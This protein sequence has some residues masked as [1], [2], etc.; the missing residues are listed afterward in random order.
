MAAEHQSELS[1]P[2]PIGKKP[3]EVESPPNYVAG[4]ER[5]VYRKGWE[6]VTQSEFDGHMKTETFHMVDR[7]P[8]GRKICKLKMV[9]RLQH[10]QKRKIAKFKVR[11]VA[12]GFIE[13]RDVYYTH[14]SSP[15]PS[16]ASIK[17]VLALAN[18]KELPLRQIYSCMTR[19]SPGVYSYMKLPGGCGEVSSNAK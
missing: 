3:N 15:C 19:R 16:S 18:E 2:S 4:V 1:I 9:F 17:L 7:V 8:K 12:R 10:G 6:E 14:S 13:I 11:L 5:S